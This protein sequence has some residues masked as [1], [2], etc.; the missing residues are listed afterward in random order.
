MHSVQSLQ[1]NIHTP[2]TL[3]HLIIQLFVKLG[4]LSLTLVFLHVGEANSRNVGRGGRLFIDYV[5]QGKNLS[6]GLL[7]VK[8]L[9]H[10][11][12]LT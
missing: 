5:V 2:V 7:F 9:L 4:Q 11:H 12:A 6:I 1:A 8:L 10:W 3:P